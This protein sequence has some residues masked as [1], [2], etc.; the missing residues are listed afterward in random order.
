[1]INLLIANGNIFLQQQQQLL[2]TALFIPY[3]FIFIKL[4]SGTL[5]VFLKIIICSHDVVNYYAALPAML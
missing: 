2:T 4:H 3:F 1:M 5:S